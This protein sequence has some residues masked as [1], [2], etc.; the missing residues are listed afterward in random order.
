VAGQDH[1]IDD[2][3]DALKSELA[4]L[5]QPQPVQ[6]LFMGG[7]TP[8]HL[9]RRQLETLLALLER[10]LPLESGHEFSVEANPRGLDS[11]KIEVLA[12]HG[13]NRLSLGAQ[14]FHR[15]LLTVLERDHDP[16]DVCRAVEQARARIANLSIDLIFGVPGQSLTEWQED[17][18]RALALGPS[19]LSTYRL[20]VRERHTVMEARAPGSGP[21]FGR[22]SGAGPV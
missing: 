1:R 5:E 16:A 21:C 7:G 18:D 15:G 22:G 3:L 20:D 4:R 13:V 6:T 8:T 12:D 17:L 14:S 10:W 19:H 9:S 11:D 2:Y